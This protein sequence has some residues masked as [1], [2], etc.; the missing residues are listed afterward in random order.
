MGV[1]G[2][3]ARRRIPP[4]VKPGCEVHRERRE[5]A[6]GTAAERWRTSPVA[7]R[8][9]SCGAI[10][11]ELPNPRAGGNSAESDAVRGSQRLM[12]VSVDSGAEIMGSAPELA[13]RDAHRGV[14]ASLLG[15]KYCGPWG[16]EQ[17]SLRGTQRF[18]E[19]TSMKSWKA[20]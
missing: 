15:V 11:V 16:Q 13:P 12:S 14:E 8:Q 2:N 1:H 5:G 18:Q 19:A 6:D 3:A 7:R 17:A 20:S 9:M 10:E 4:T